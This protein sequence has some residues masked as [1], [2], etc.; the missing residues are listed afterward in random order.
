MAVFLLRAWTYDEYIDLQAS[1]ALVEIGPQ[2][3]K[4]NLERMDCAAAIHEEDPDFYV[5]EYWNYAPTWVTDNETLEELLGDNETVSLDVWPEI[6]CDDLIQQDITRMVVR[7]N[8]IYWRSYIKHTN[9]TMDSAYIK[10]EDLE[11]IA[12]YQEGEY[13]NNVSV[14]AL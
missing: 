8:E 7:Q 12:Q 5:L 10:R 6:S 13:A 2:A 4:Y 9:V 14:S 1:F 3:A 11:P